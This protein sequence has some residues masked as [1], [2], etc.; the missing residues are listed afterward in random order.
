MGG[1]M[2]RGRAGGL[3]EVLD[4]VGERV[5]GWVGGWDC[6]LYEESA[7]ALWDVFVPVVGGWMNEFRGK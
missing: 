1:W 2:G 3:N 4:S 5:G 6:T 7:R